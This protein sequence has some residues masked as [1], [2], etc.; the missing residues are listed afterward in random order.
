MHCGMLSRSD[1]PRLGASIL[2]AAV[3]A[4]VNGRSESGGVVDAFANERPPA[5]QLAA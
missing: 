5:V 1:R 4:S 2:A 3:S